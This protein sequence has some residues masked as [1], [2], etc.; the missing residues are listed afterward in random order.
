RPL[1][2]IQLRRT[3]L[4]LTYLNNVGQPVHGWQTP[5]GYAFDAATWMV[6]EAL[7]RRAD[8]A[9]ALAQR[10][11]E[12]VFLRPFLEPETLRAIAI[13]PAALRAGLMLASADFM[14]K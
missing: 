13:Q 7:T 12:P 8:C 1:S 6:P 14:R 11:D 4:A 9:L 5:D 10:M 2:P 3:V